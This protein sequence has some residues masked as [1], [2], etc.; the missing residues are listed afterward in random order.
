MAGPSCSL[1]R[2]SPTSLS[3]DAVVFASS[4]LTSLTSLTS[5]TSLLESDLASAFVSTKCPESGEETHVSTYVLGNAYLAPGR[6]NAPPLIDPTLGNPPSPYFLLPNIRSNHP[7]TRPAPE[8]ILSARVSSP[9]LVCDRLSSVSAKGM[10]GVDGR[11]VWDR[12]GWGSKLERFV[13]FFLV[14]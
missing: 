12:G 11:S 14:F 4:S 2:V 3:V 7:S 5:S 9:V 8:A 1:S 13:P 10:L 6:R